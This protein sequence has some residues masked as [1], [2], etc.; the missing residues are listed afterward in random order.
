MSNFEFNG[1]LYRNS[2]SYHCGIAREWLCGNGVGEARDTFAEEP[3]NKKLA[4]ECAKALDLVEFY[5]EEYAEANGLYW[6]YD[7][8]EDH[9]ETEF[10]LSELTAAIADL[11]AEVM[12]PTE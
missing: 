9:E 7:A 5:D 12:A 11:R 1:L 2:E 6:P 4:L 3:S 8:D 10:S